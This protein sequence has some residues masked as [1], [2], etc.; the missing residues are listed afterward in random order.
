MTGHKAAGMS[1]EL[2]VGQSDD[3]ASRGDCVGL[4]EYQAAFE[5]AYLITAANN[6]EGAALLAE[7]GS[8][9]IGASRS[10]EDLTSTDLLAL[11]AFLADVA[12]ELELVIAP[13]F[14]REWHQLQI[15]TY[16]L[17][18][19]FLATMSVNG[20]EYATEEF[21]PRIAALRLKTGEGPHLGSDCPVFEL[22]A[23]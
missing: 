20:Q 16:R 10:M 23:A 14:A 2:V 21:A 13:E 1:G 18:G 3:V 9:E 22:W 19:E 4:G 8:P 17:L 6:P 5:Y 15:D 12:N 11:S 7:L